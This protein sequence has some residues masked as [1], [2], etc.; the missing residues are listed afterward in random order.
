M[1][2]LKSVPTIALSVLIIA[3]LGATLLLGFVLQELNPFRTREYTDIG[4]TVVQSVRQL[5][6]LTTV[7]VV[8]TTTIEKGSDRG[9]LDLL[10]GDRIYLFAVGRIGAGVD[11]AS[12][13]ER[14]FQ[15][16][17][18]TKRARL[19]LPPPQVF[20]V[21]LDNNETRVFDRD[22][23]L[24]TKGDRELESEARAAA[25]GVLR[26]QALN[27]NILGIAFDNAVRTLTVFLRSVGYTEVEIVPRGNRQ[28]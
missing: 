15:L 13:E 1:L 6:E 16:D 24:L 19:E 12:L 3:V 23:G 20:Y 14:D 27:A 7:E 21:E 4:P 25:E 28:G 17:P 11:L 8:Q 9:I 5:S 26:E 18:T 2:V 10:R 22:T